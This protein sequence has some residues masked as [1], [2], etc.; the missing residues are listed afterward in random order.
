MTEHGLAVLSQR[1][2]GFSV[3]T[4]EPSHGLVLSGQRIDEPINGHGPFV[5]NTY[6]EII[7]AYEDVKAGRLG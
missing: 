6:E 4:L 2:A 5:I 3:H 1:G 7:L